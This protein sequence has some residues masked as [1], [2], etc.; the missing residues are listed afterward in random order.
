MT[1]TAVTNTAGPSGHPANEARN[2]RQ[3]RW[4]LPLVILCVAFI[5]FSLPPYLTFDPSQSRLPGVAPL[6]ST[7]FVSQVGNTMLALL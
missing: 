1:N 4:M 3:L 6:S 2:R 7:G 5:A